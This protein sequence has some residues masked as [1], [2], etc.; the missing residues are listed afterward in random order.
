M[1]S[2]E[3]A[4]ETLP[5]VLRERAICKLRHTNVSVFIYIF[6]ACM[7]CVAALT[8]SL[9]SGD[10]VLARGVVILAVIVIFAFLLTSGA[11]RYMLH[12]IKSNNF[13]YTYATV[14]NIEYVKTR[15]RRH[16]AYVYVDD[17]RVLFVGSL[18]NG[19]G[20]KCTVLRFIKNGKSLMPLAIRV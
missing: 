12:C 4:G 16:S 20:C 19:I 3:Y 18:H 2:Q 10:F 7:P 15:K 5:A 11:E 6:I 17:E 13:T 9:L 14:T 8:S 1:E